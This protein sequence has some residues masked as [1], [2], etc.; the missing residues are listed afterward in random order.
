MKLTTR[1]QITLVFHGFVPMLT[2]GLSPTDSMFR[3]ALNEYNMRQHTR[4]TAR[5]MPTSVSPTSLRDPSCQRYRR[6]ICWG[7]AYIFSIWVQAPNRYITPM[8][9]R[10]IVVAVIL[11][12]TDRNRMTP[13]GT[14][15]MTNALEIS[16][17][18]PE[19][20]TMEIPRTTNTAAPKAAP[21]E[22]PVV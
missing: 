4:H 1:R 13:T 8:P 19:M 22:T 20:G 5:T 21:E 11:L 15:D 6:S 16:P 2:A 17:V 14:R 12:N 3:S 7:V 18:V 9:T 10:I